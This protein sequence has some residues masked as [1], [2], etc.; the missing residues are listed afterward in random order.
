MFAAGL[1]FL[2]EPL[3]GTPLNR[4]AARDWV[5]L[6]AAAYGGYDELMGFPATVSLSSSLSPIQFSEEMAASILEFSRGGQALCVA[7]LILTGS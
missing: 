4:R 5:E 1:F 3:M 6:I 7:A 2:R